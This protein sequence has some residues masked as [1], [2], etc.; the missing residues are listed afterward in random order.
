MANEKTA[1]APPPQ[2][3]PGPPPPRPTLSGLCPND[4]GLKAGF[5]SGNDADAVTFRPIVGWL[6]VTN[7]AK[8]TTIGPFLAVVVSDIGLPTIVVGNAFPD[9][10]GIFP[11]DTSPED[12]RAKYEQWRAKPGGGRGSPPQS[13]N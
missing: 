7:F 12:A 1:P 5:W 9:H 8:G 4:L 10:I 3:A 13:F 2:P 6:V 11:N